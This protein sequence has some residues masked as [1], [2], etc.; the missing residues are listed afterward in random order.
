MYTFQIKRVLREV[1]LLTEMIAGGDLLDALELL[2]I[3]LDR[4][5]A[6]FYVPAINLFLKISEDSWILMSQIWEQLIRPLQF[7]AAEAPTRGHC[8]TRCEAPSSQ[9][10][11]FHDAPDFPIFAEK[12][13]R[14]PPN[15]SEA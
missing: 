5:M 14:D 7:C 1:Y 13:E 12:F 10:L 15:I 9:A 11:D 3:I 2:G 6:Q 4:G 8:G